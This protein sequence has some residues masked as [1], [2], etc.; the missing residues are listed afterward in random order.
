MLLYSIS[1]SRITLQKNIH[2][3][4]GTIVILFVMIVTLLIVRYLMKN[5]NRN[6]IQLEDTSPYFEPDIGAKLDTSTSDIL[7]ES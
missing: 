7:L 4:T 5:I 2:N 1:G 6:R 3:T